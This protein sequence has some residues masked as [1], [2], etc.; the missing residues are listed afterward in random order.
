M[1]LF[2]IA[3][4]VDILEAAPQKFMAADRLMPQEAWLPR[5][6]CRPGTL[7]QCKSVTWL[8]L[9]LTCLWTISCM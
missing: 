9:V 1:H 6:D 3:P 4:A 5:A 8:V 2:T 7:L